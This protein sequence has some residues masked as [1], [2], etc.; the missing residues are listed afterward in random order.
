MEE[1]DIISEIHILADGA[2][3]GWLVKVTGYNHG[4][5]EF[6]EAEQ[7]CLFLQAVEELIAKLRKQ[8]NG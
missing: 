4:R 8:T 1:I 3:G 5:E 6:V 7:Q 2:R